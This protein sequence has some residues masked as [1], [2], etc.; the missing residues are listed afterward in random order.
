ML[1]A[2]WQTVSARNNSAWMILRPLFPPI[3]CAN[4][5]ASYVRPYT[6]PYMQRI[7]WKP[8]TY[9]RATFLLLVLPIRIDSRRN[10]PTPYTLSSVPYRARIPTP[11]KY[12]QR[13]THAPQIS[14]P[15]QARRCTSLLACFPACYPAHIPPTP[16]RLHGLLWE[17]R[18]QRAHHPPTLATNAANGSTTKRQPPHLARSPTIWRRK[19]SRSHCRQFR[20]PGLFR[21][22]FPQRFAPTI[23]N[24]QPAEH[25]AARL[26]SALATIRQPGPYQPPQLAP[27]GQRSPLFRRIFADD[28]PQRAPALL[29]TCLHIYARMYEFL[30]IRNENYIPYSTNARKALILPGF[31]A[32]IL[33]TRRK[34]VFTQD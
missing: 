7:T 22:A 20:Q 6:P 24:R 15:L 19:A 26:A 16:Q 30:H 2:R 25:K 9:K 21:P 1:Q 13:A 29:R 34:K 3:P 4:N 27:N 11:R 5:S 31:K 32:C 10:V 14:A 17:D 18:S 8:H 28:P 23:N 33:Y 12:N